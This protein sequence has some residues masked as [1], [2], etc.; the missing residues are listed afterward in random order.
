[1]YDT[2][3]NKRDSTLV[4]HPVGINDVHKN[5][6]HIAVYPNPANNTLFFEKG[7]EYKAAHVYTIMGQRV[8]IYPY[9]DTKSIDVSSLAKGSYFL[10][11]IGK[12][13]EMLGWAKFVKTAY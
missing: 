1:M 4:L 12:K 9:N 5:V 3:W 6:P 7:P 8:G 11:L 13:E 10:K 2:I